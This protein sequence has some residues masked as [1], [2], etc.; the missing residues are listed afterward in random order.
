MSFVCLRQEVKNEN[1]PVLLL[2]E[3]LG[4]ELGLGVWAGS[5]E[6]PLEFEQLA[7][8]EPVTEN[9]NLI[10]EHTVVPPNRQLEIV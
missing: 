1:K 6:L 2:L 3:W 7:D 10:N 4:I 5:M 8:D 9:I